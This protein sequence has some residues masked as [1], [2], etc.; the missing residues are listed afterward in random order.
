MYKSVQ[1]SL[2]FSSSWSS[3]NHP[4]GATG[5]S[6]YFYFL[7]IL[8]V[9]VCFYSSHILNAGLLLVSLH[10]FYLS[11]RSEYVFHYMPILTKM[12]FFVTLTQHFQNSSFFGENKWPTSQSAPW[13]LTGKNISEHTHTHTRTHTHTY[14]SHVCFCADRFNQQKTSQQLTQRDRRL[15]VPLKQHNYAVLTYKPPCGKTSEMIQSGFNK[16]FNRSSRRGF[17]VNIFSSSAHMNT[18]FSAKVWAVWVILHEIFLCFFVSRS[19]FHWFEVGGAYIKKG[20]IAYFCAP[21]RI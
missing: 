2:F 3:N 21:I 6:E 9:L 4:T 20:D 7:L 12:L 5:A 17:N 8:V 13:V 18:L 19:C 1:I 10:Y 14:L 11:K 16:C 15:L